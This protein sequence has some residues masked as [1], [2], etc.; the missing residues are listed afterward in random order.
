M[1]SHEQ[2]GASRREDD[3]TRAPHAAPPWHEM[4][5]FRA[6]AEVR[7]AFVKGGIPLATPR[8]TEASAR[9]AVFWALYELGHLLDEIEHRSR[10][11]EPCWASVRASEIRPGRVVLEIA[12]EPIPSAPSATGGLP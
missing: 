11:G 5:E 8:T 3:R 6:L 12:I 9:L 1:M 2:H 10:A 7:R 4:P